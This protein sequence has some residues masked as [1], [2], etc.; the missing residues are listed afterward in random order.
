M[1]KTMHNPEPLF[2]SSET[3]DLRSD[4]VTT[5]TEAM[6]EAMC[7]APVGDDVY[8]EDP[9]T[10]RLQ[11]SV[12]AMFGKEAALF[13]PSGTLGNQLAIK[14]HTEPGDEVLVDSESHIFHYETAAP[15]IISN[16]QLRCV[17]S[18]WGV[19][20]EETLASLKASVRPSTY[21]YPRTRLLCL[22]NT[23]NR[24]GGAVLP[25]STIEACA[26]FAC[27][28]GLGFHCDGARLWNACAASDIEPRV[29]GEHFDTLSVC[30]SKGLG[31]PVGSVLV[32]TRALI[33]KA[34]KWRKIL[35]SGMRQTGM[36]AA[37]GL[38]ALEHHRS[39]LQGDH[40]RAKG[41]AKLLSDSP[42]FDVDMQRV[43]TNIVLFSCKVDIARLVEECGRD[44]ILFASIQAGV[45]RVVFHHQV[46]ASHTEFA[47]RRIIA[48]AERLA[49]NL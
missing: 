48:I 2:S 14:A 42:L 30:L 47:A 25:L 33:D 17:L 10:N 15:S 39:L 44:G 5:P 9:T 31:A 35:G 3:I 49:G 16:V 6:R 1:K 34:H 26:A 21:Y 28:H 45:A 32:G 40:E 12:A 29:Y 4:T 8:G 13:V 37:A 41:F 38:Y 27:E 11:E 23:H 7:R 18:D 20:G 19:M 36:L 46:S 22:E 43:Q 24:Y